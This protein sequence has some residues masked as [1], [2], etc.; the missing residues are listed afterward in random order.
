MWYNMWYN[1]WYV[2][3]L[4]DMCCNMWW[5]YDIQIEYRHNTNISVS[6]DCN[7]FPSY[8]M[9][10]NIAAPFQATFLD[11]VQKK[12]RKPRRQS[13]YT[14]EERA[15]LGKYKDEYRRM[16]NVEERDALFRNHILVDMFNYW[17]GK[18]IVCGDISEEDTAVRIKVSQMF[19]SN[20]MIINVALLPVLEIGSMDLEQLAEVSQG[21]WDRYNSAE[22]V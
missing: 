15:V 21:C 9:T 5:V 17:Y 1:M 4:S 7:P 12:T 13:E 8:T 22:T 3:Q 14:V 2:R 19:V 10:M 18:G 20:N 16:S 6:T 11:A